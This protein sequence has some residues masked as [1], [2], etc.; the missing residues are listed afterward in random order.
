MRYFLFALFGAF[1][2]VLLPFIFEKLPSSWLC[3][4]GET[5]TDAHN[6]PRLH[7][8]SAVPACAACLSF[9]CAMVSTQPYGLPTAL[10]LCPALAVLM[11]IAISDMKYTIIPDQFVILLAALAAMSSLC[12]YLT[13]EKIFMA[14][15]W[16]PIA[17]GALVGGLL[18]LTG[19]AGSLLFKKEAM[20]FGDVKLAAAV[21]ILAGFPSSLT[22]LLLAIL[23]AGIS[24]LAAMLARRL[25]SGDVRPF[26]PFI[27]LATALFVAFWGQIQAFIG[28]YISLIK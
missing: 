24:F 9:L 19:L 6:P 13:G 21:G 27:A 7:L 4:Y 22:V 5:P 14:T 8:S 11:L 2:G 17:G 16:S 23:I 10:L 15:L 18:L 28:W 26:G 20:G 3:D 1:L 12:D 25:S